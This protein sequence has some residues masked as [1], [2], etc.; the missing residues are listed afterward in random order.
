MAKETL[1]RPDKDLV[2]EQIKK[3]KQID[4]GLQYIVSAH[5]SVQYGATEAAQALYNHRLRRT[6]EEM[7]IEQ[8]NKSKQG[9]RLSLLRDAGVNNIWQVTKLSYSRLCAIDGVGEQ[10]ARKI[11]DTARQI[12]ENTK[13]SLRIRIEA[14][15]PHETDKGQ[16]D[17]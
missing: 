11:L 9:L 13:A 16:A 12:T 6:L 10:S 1:T 2:Q 3:A 7:D 8:L 5:E 14:Q 15:N 17:F 4:T